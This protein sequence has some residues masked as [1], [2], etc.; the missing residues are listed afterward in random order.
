[1]RKGMLGLLV[2]VLT[3]LTGALCYGSTTSNQLVQEGR[4]LL[5]NSG[6]PT[7]SGVIAA[8]DQFAGA[9]QSDP[10]D[11]KAHFF[12]AVTRILAS[13][14][15]QGSGPGLSTIRDLLE[16]WGFSWNDNDSLTNNSL[17]TPPVLDENPPPNTI[18]AGAALQRYLTG[19][20]V[21]LLNASLA[22][23]KAIKN[24]PQTFVITLTRSETGDL[25]VIIDYGDLLVLKSMLYSQK[26]VILTMTSWNMAIDVQQLISKGNMGVLQVQRDLLDAYPNLLHLQTNGG[27]R[28]GSAKAALLAAIDS[29]GEAFSFISQ[30][31]RLQQDNHLFT[32]AS[33][34]EM[35]RA[36]QTLTTLTEIKKS[37]AG[38]RPANFGPDSP[39]IDFNRLFGNTGKPPLDIR[40]T[41]PRFTAEGRI[42]PAAPIPSPLFGGLLPDIVT[43]DDAIAAFGDGMIATIPEA[44]G[45]G[46]AKGGDGQAT[47]T[48]TPPDE[49]GGAPVVRYTV[50]AKPGGLSVRG[51]RSPL[52][53]TGLTN[54]KPYTFTVKAV[55]KVGASP[56]S[57]PS[58]TVI[59]NLPRYTVAVPG[60]SKVAAIAA[61]LG[62]VVALKTDGT[63]V[64]WGDNWK[65][66][67]AVPVG[68]NDV[69][70]IA[71]GEGH[72]VAL[73]NDG[74][75]V[76]WGSNWPGLSS[77]PVGLSGVKAIS[78]GY[79][80]TVVLKNNGTVVAW[81]E[82]WWGQCSVPPGL[83]G[84]K[85]IAAGSRHTAALMNDGTVVAWGYNSSGECS[86]PLGLSGVKAIAAGDMHTV[87][88]KNDGTVVA[89]GANGYGQSAVPLGLTGVKAIA[90]GYYHT[91]VLKNNGTVMAWGYNSNGQSSVPAGLGNVTAIAAGYWHTEAVKANGTVAVWGEHWATPLTIPSELY[92]P[93][94]AKGTI[95]C[96]SPVTAGANALCTMTPKPGYHLATFKVNGG[97]RLS[98]VVDNTFTITNIQKDQVVRGSFVLN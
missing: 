98:G 7:V 3:L 41:L 45:M 26:A 58:N 54:G 10:S 61:G 21:Q 30:D 92:N 86:V 15:Q 1:M 28:L 84:V 47:I 76:A 78:V 95:T 74:T 93:A 43:K 25:P 87:A 16:S 96:A 27:A 34:E 57:A 20:F 17:Y 55:N 14:G 62:H 91:V 24:T 48:F 37:L 97:D 19:P 75:I 70:A 79:M 2:G 42:L 22:D 83:S 35:D 12:L 88:L 8:N 73:K 32:F 39:R 40:A 9:V 31:T 49:N 81:G 59:P 13:L 29:Y 94:K 51:T 23:L 33:Q 52:T 38:N 53:V 80:D 67:T 66:Q 44:P 85:A 63:V 69:R 72:T 36:Q 64:A 60:F 46:L 6:G 4:V 11:R 68:L 71:A 82:N 89:W 18:P 65:G 90:A 50:T 5:F 77:S 56:A